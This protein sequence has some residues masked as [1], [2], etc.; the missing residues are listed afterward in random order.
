MSSYE[1]NSGG[2]LYHGGV[3]LKEHHLVGREGVWVLFRVREMAAIRISPLLASAIARLPPNGL[4]A[5]RLMQELRGCHLVADADAEAGRPSQGGAAAAIALPVRAILFLAQTCTMRCI[6]CYGDGGE[7]GE[8]GL[9]TAA[10]ARAA[11]D[12]LMAH[13]GDARQVSIGFFGGEPLLNMAVLKQVVDY[14]KKRAA[15]RTMAIAFTVNT[16]GSLLDDAIAE[17]L[18]RESI[19][20]RI[21]FDGPRDVQNRQRPFANGQG[22][23]EQVVARLP[24]LRRQMPLRAVRAT[25]CGN[26]DPFAVRQGLEDVG[27][28]ACTLDAASPM[29]G[30]EAGRTERDAGPPAQVPEQ[31]ALR[32]L[33]YRRD[34]VARYF[35]S[36]RS[37]RLDLE[38]PCVLTGLLSALATGRR[39]HSACGAGRGLRAVSAAGEVYPCHRFVGHREFQMG[40]LEDDPAAV[41]NDCH[42]VFVDT[43]PACSSCPVRYLCGGG[44]LYHNWAVTGDLRQV[45]P[46]RCRERRVICEELIHGWAMLSAAERA[47]FREQATRLYP[48][49]QGA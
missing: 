1:V 21:S 5:D 47:Y 27:F 30:H 7:Y 12:W 16:N 35:N 9:M 23:Y 24:L 37:R 49:T 13:C 33:A 4:I 22:S 3:V 32:M 25:V 31:L 20:V 46:V 14:A 29:V 15:E 8:S 28:T 44:C 39:N 10:T 48:E 34:E 40:R 2:R 36:V 11:V 6:Y 38:S 26:S 17:Y 18:A 41:P 19:H 42:R 43:I 45:D